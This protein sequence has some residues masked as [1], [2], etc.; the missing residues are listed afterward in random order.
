MAK[1]SINVLI[2]GDASKLKRALGDAESRMDK[3]KGAAGTF[4]KAAGAAFAAAGVGAGILGKQSIGAASDLEESLSKIKA[5]FDGNAQAIIDW[6]ETSAQAFG[7]SK[8]QALEAAGTYGNLFQ[9]FG[10]GQEPAKEMS[11][12]LV[13]LAADLASF[14]NTSIDDALQALQS[15]LSGE[16]EPLKRYGVALN[17]ARLKQVALELG[18]YDGVG[19]LTAAQK[20]QAAYELV[21][22]DTTLAQGDFERTSDGL[23]NKQRIM[24][25]EWEN[26]KATIGTAL[27]PAMTSIVS[28]ITS[29]VIPTVQRLAEEWMPKLRAA[30]ETVSAFVEENWPKV[31]AVVGA[32]VDWFQ[33]YVVPV[34]QAV[35]GFIN[36][37]FGKLV[38]WVRENWD[39]IKQTIDSTIGAI[40]LIIENV[41]AAIQFIWEHWGDEIS[42]YVRLV[43]DNMKRYIEAAINII[44]GVIQ[45]VTSLIRGDWSGVWDGIKSIVEGVLGIIKTTISGAMTAIRLLMRAAWDG[46]KLAVSAAWDAIVGYVRDGIDGVVDFVVG[47]PGRIADAA[48]GAFDA[49]WEEFKSV[50]NRIIGGWNGLEFSIPGVSVPGPLPDIPGFTIGTPNIPTFDTGGV[51]PGALGAPTLALVHGG[52]TI[53][54][55]HKRAMQ[56]TVVVSFEGANFYGSPP[57]RWASELAGQID[58]IQRG[59]A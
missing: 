35:A 25:A 44:R 16:T 8:Q 59:A 29:D 4:A 33:T 30:F 43:W 52:E 21:L 42:A 10:I 3:F 55:T 7:M 50:M 53:L 11:Q 14:N 2:T 58:R 36:E 26:A 47:L 6:S 22:R 20:A 48:A 57:D 32:V 9:A 17:D 1:S 37:E 18:I 38:G 23:A 31:Q 46:I 27:L 41:T 19:A 13:E 12:S 45:V 40:R 54:P 24:S 34:I 56:P 5:V 49:V 51:V 28:A 15:G 39:E